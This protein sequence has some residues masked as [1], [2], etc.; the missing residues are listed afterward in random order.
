[1]FSHFSTNFFLKKR[2]K[3]KKRVQEHLNEI[4]NAIAGIPFS[5]ELN[6]NSEKSAKKLRLN[7]FGDEEDEKGHINSSHQNGKK[8]LLKKNIRPKITQVSKHIQDRQSENI[9]TG[10]RIFRTISILEVDKLTKDEKKN[11]LNYVDAILPH[12]QV[13]PIVD[14]STPNW[15]YLGIPAPSFRWLMVAPTRTG[16]TTLIINILESYQHVFDDIYIFS[17]TL[18]SDRNWREVLNDEF[19]ETHCFDT[20]SEEKLKEICGKAIEEIDSKDFAKKKF[21]QILIIGDDIIDQLTNRHAPKFAEICFLRGRHVG[22][23]MLLTSQNYML[24]PKTMRLNCEFIT[25]FR[26]RNAVEYKS[27]Y[28]EQGTHLTKREWN[29]I[30]NKIL[31]IPHN[32]ICFD[33]CV[34]LK[35]RIRWNLDQCV[36]PIENE[37]KKTQEIFPAELKKN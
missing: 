27:V 33:H 36:I 17:N 5:Y 18:K 15:S 14:I 19:V 35:Y 13:H 3:M 1:M 12:L 34:R 21:K 9:V 29:V 8:S 6:E 22:I 30:S 32:F 28:E 37:E 16:K 4:K 2:E 20:Y 23:S 7:L 26:L 11:E 31:S 10:D 24:F 25:I